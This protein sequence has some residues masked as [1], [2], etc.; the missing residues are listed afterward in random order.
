[1]ECIL[2]F[3]EVI[4][5]WFFFSS[6]KWHL[7][8]H[9]S[10]SI[11]LK[12]EFLQFHQFYWPFISFY[13]FFYFLNCLFAH[14]HQN[15]EIMIFFSLLKSHAYRQLGKSATTIKVKLNENR[16]LC[17]SKIKIKIE[18]YV[19]VLNG[20]AFEDIKNYQFCIIQYFWT[21]FPFL[22]TI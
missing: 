18:T 10:F 15:Y 19:L 13:V 4:I 6:W 7:Q 1:M 2:R 22:Y 21:W 9:H 17:F 20:W 16:V 14:E 11:L 3:I 8:N 12:Y 5:W